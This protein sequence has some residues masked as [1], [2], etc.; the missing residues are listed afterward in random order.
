MTKKQFCEKYGH[1]RP[2]SY[3]IESKSYNEAFNEYF[4]SNKIYKNLKIK[5]NNFTT[6]QNKEIKNLL[7]KKNFPI[8]FK[9]LINFTKLSIEMRELSKFH[10]T[11]I[12]NAIFNQIKSLANEV[13]IKYYDFKFISIQTLLDAYNNLSLR[14][15]KT[16]LVTEIKKNK[17]TMLL[18]NSIKLPDFINKSE[19]I[20]LF[21]LS[22]S[23]GNFVTNKI[24]TGKVVEYKK[25]KRNK[26]YEDCI[27]LIENADPGFDFLFSHNI[28][29]FISKYGGANSHM[30]IRCLELG[31]PAII[32]IGQKNYDDIKKSKFIQFDCKQ[33][34]LKKIN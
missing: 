19:D 2:Q 24:C 29:G 20:Y 4:T 21:Y 10:F 31:I 33:K 11:K 15:L 13:D 26:N 9:E 6:L 23:T 1:L 32:G 7:L 16:I 22:V 30:S 8:S 25:N 28:K 3:S 12:L 5:K 27:V 14:K 17:E 18:S 34:I